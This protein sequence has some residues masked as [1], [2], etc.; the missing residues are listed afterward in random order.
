VDGQLAAS[1]PN[2]GPWSWDPSEQIELGKSYDSFWRRFDGYLDDVQ[3]YNRSLSAAEVAE[4]FQSRPALGVGRTGN[5]LTFS[6]SETGFVLQENPNVTNALGWN[7]VA[8]GST[9]P[10][11][12]TIPATGNNF[13]RLRK[14]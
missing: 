5:Q 9:G 14:P 3:F 10:V 8:G 7:N 1:N 4:I 11:T 13:Y 2:S 12:V 6:W